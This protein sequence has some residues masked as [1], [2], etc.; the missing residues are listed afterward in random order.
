MPPGSRVIVNKSKHFKGEVKR[1]DIVTIVEE[2][3]EFIV[4]ASTPVH[5]IPPNRFFM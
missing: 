1:S 4:T 3:D 5:S 2:G